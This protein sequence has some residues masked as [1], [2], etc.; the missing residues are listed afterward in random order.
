MKKRDEGTILFVGVQS[1][2]YMR[3]SMPSE[4]RH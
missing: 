1:S 2:E 3:V 4:F